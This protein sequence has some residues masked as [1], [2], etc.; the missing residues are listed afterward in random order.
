MST[1]KALEQIVAGFA[2]DDEATVQDGYTKV[3]AAGAR[4]CTYAQQLGLV[5]CGAPTRG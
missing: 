5:S 3:G 4:T 2:A 1:R